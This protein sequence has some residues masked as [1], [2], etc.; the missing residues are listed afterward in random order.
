MKKRVLAVLLT[1]VM[2]ITLVG[3]GGSTKETTAATD[4]GSDAAATTAPEA[5]DDTAAESPAGDKIVIGVAMKTLSDEF[6]K[7]VADAIEAGAAEMDN[8]ELLVNDAQAD[9]ATQMEQVENLIAN[10]VDVIIL[11]PQDADGL[12]SAVEACVAAGVPVVECNT[13]TSNED[14]DCF[15]GSRDVEAGEIQGEFVKEQ[16][17]GEGEIAIMEGIMGQSGQIDRLEGVNNTLVNGNDKITVVAE[18]SANW[19]RDEAMA[20]AENWIV[21]NPNLKAIMCQNDDM[22]LGALEAVKNAGKQEDIIVVG[23][24]AIGEAV[25]AVEAGELACTVFQDAAGQGQGALEA[26]VAI[27]N[28]ES[29]E[30][31]VVIPF[32]LVTQE[33][34]AQFK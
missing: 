5:A 1:T 26:A 2:G 30:K 3:C 20:L 6:P 16:I 14:Y 24:D 19:Q 11:N 8:V 10:N 18:Q 29:V 25:E 33:N 15:V 13:R 21:S 4:S 31:E 28:G 7:Q 17:G 23:V 9:V 27:V 12:N 32:Q 34:A 22:A